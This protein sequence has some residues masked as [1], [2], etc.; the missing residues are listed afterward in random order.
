MKC[1]TFYFFPYVLSSPCS[2]LWFRDWVHSW[3][4]EK[5]ILCCFS[6][7]TLACPLTA[8][9]KTTGQQEQ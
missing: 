6:G 2:V 9:F 5:E 4:E 8:G 3:L 7:F 1:L